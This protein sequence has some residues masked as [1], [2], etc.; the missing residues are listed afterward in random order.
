MTILTTFLDVDPGFLVKRSTFLVSA[1][2]EVVRILPVSFAN[3]QFIDS[4]VVPL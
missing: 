3:T 1:W 4:T 2:L